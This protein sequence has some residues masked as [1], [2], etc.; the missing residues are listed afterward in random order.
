MSGPSCAA[1]RAALMLLQGTETES[2]G[3]RF[4]EPGQISA[5]GVLAKLLGVGCRAK[6]GRSTR[7]SAGAPE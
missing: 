4:K 6:R 3:L 2:L 1:K 7:G 5:S